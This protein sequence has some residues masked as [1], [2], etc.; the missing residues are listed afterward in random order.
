MD[1]TDILFEEIEK[2]G[3]MLALVD[4]TLSMVAYGGLEGDRK[5]IEEAQREFKEKYLKV[6]EAL[7]NVAGTSKAGAHLFLAC[8]TFYTL[9]RDPWHSSMTPEEALDS[10]EDAKYEAEEAVQR[11]LVVPALDK[12]MGIYDENDIPRV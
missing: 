5:F 1:L 11:H 3:D 6:Y 10:A 12:E 4:N 8:R 2:V 9:Y 7:L